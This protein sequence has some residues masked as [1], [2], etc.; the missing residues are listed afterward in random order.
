M[1]GKIRQETPRSPLEPWTG[2]V[3]AATET[4]RQRAAGHGRI[5]RLVSMHSMS[6]YQMQTV[7]VPKRDGAAGS[8]SVVDKIRRDIC[9]LTS[10]S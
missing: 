2:I 8:K 3:S 10:E 9:R 4:Q 7:V 1:K 6:L 5:L